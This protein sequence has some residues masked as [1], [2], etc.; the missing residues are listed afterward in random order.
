MFAFADRR[1]Q[2]FFW[3]RECKIDFLWKEV[4]IRYPE[5]CA[6]SAWTFCWCGWGLV[7]YWTGRDRSRNRTVDDCAFGQDVSEGPHSNS[8]FERHNRI[9]HSVAFGLL[10]L[11]SLNFEERPRSRA[12]IS[13]VAL[14]VEAHWR[15]HWSDCELVRH[16]YHG[17][18]TFGPIADLRWVFFFA[19][20]NGSRLK[21][22]LNYLM[23][24]L[25]NFK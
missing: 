2:L 6:A 21:I 13:S 24:N 11:L 12:P 17:R 7:D 16:G 8:N 25:N 10:S 14:F 20:E 18:P 15:S 9:W 22:I 1:K 5:S 23:N 4:L 3:I 19:Y